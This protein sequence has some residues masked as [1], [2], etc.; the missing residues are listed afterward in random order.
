MKID[1]E[2][3]VVEFEEEHEDIDD[4]EDLVSEL[5]DSTPRFVVYTYYFTLLWLL[6]PY[7]DENNDNRGHVRERTVS[8][9]IFILETSFY[10]HNQHI[11]FFN[12][13]QIGNCLG[14]DEGIQL[15]CVTSNSKVFDVDDP[16]QLT[17][18]WLMNKLKR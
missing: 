7:Q 8:Y 15:A 2:K 14:N 16:E 13:E 17:H 11:V 6:K 9:G 4:I 1:Q 18:D 3:L 10:Y 12:K 5:P